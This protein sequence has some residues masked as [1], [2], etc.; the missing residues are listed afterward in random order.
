MRLFLADLADCLRFWSRLPIPAAPDGYGAPNFARII[1]ALPFAGALIA[2]PGALVLF[3]AAFFEAPPLA[4]AGLALLA[5]AMTTGGFHED[6]FADCADSMGG[7]TRERRLEIMKDSRVGTFGA[8]AV[9]F[10]VLL[11]A[12][13]LAS[14][15]LVSP[16]LAVVAFIGVAGFARTCGLL[17]LALLPTARVDGM[18]ALAQARNHNLIIAFIFAALSALAPL[19]LGLSHSRVAIAGALGVF[20]AAATIPFARSAYGGATGDVA[21]AAEQLCEIAYLLALSAGLKALA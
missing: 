4:S 19:A 1:R 3:L 5:L 16:L 10:S 12:S 17:P 21:G 2:L 13:A 15:L 11:R 6:G 9:A 18:G 7:Y 14:L 8:L 20:A